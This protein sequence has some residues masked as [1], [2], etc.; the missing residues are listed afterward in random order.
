M[1]RFVYLDNSATTKVSERVFEAM[2]PYLTEHYGNPSGS[3][4]FS[5]QYP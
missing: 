5:N 1:D 3:L 2:V 4:C